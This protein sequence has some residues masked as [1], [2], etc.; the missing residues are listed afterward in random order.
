MPARGFVFL[1]LR[2]PHQGFLEVAECTDVPAMH[3]AEERKQPSPVVRVGMI[4]NRQALMARK[5]YFMERPHKPSK[6]CRAENR[7]GTGMQRAQVHHGLVDAPFPACGSQFRQRLFAGRQVEMT[8]RIHAD[9]FIG[10]N[11]V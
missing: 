1:T 2:K 5:A 8:V 7:L 11:D 10:A 6:V 4:K 3:G 9:E